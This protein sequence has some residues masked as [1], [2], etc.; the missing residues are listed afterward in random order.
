V[1]LQSTR[2]SVCATKESVSFGG[3]IF[4][5]KVHLTPTTPARTSNPPPT[6]SNRF[7]AT[8]AREK[9]GA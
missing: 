6:R 2:W 7:R 9:H 5:H 4:S 3:E 8:P 1:C